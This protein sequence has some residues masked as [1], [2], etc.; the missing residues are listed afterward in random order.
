ML[1]LSTL[2]DWKTVSFLVLLLVGG[3]GALAWFVPGVMVFLLGSKLG[4]LILFVGGIT[5]FV[6]IAL[7]IVFA[8]GK[9]AERLVQLQRRQQAVRE[10]IKTDVEIRD[11][12]ADDRR[13]R[14]DKWVR[15]DAGG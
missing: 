11:L 12:S 13:K 15:D 6:L 3:G 2:L 9:A 1:S 8:R 5:I 14:L 7:A 10:R 4:R